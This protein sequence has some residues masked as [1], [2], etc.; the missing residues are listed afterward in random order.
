MQYLCVYCGSSE[1][2]DHDLTAGAEAV[3]RSMARAGYGLVYGGSS[4]GTMGTLAKAVLAAG[5][6]VCGVV[7]KVLGKRELN[8]LELTE[9]IFVDTMAER[10]QMMADKADAFVALPGE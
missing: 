10:K 4:L 6:P 9:M 5:M 2:I 7:P 1:P 8:E 3:G